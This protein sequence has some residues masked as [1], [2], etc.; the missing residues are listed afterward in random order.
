MKLIQ[1]MLRKILKF[2]QTIFRRKQGVIDADRELVER[3]A[4]SLNAVMLDEVTVHDVLMT[5]EVC[6]IKYCRNEV[7]Q[8]YGD[9]YQTFDRSISSYVQELFNEFR[10][11]NPD[12]PAKTEKEFLRFVNRKNFLPSDA[13]DDDEN[14]EKFEVADQ[15]TELTVLSWYKRIRPPI[16]Q[17]A[18]R[19]G[20]D[21][22]G[23]DPRSALEYNQV[24]LPNQNPSSIAESV[25]RSLEDMY[26]DYS[27]YQIESDMQFDSDL[28]IESDWYDCMSSIE[29]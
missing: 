5:L 28:Q 4:F 2:I 16:T 3:L 21:R 17:L 19:M 27:D 14:Y 22:Y 24:A 25:L 23:G 29:N 1:R 6:G 8:W 7:F 18:F 12:S 10:F 13:L 15:R 11:R 20:L 9:W 26:S